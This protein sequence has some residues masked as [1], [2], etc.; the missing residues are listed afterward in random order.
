MSTKLRR[1]WLIV[2]LSV[3]ALALATAAAVSIQTGET[4]SAQE[5]QTRPLTQQEAQKVA[6]G[7]KQLVNKSTEGLV[8]VQHADGT[9]S[10]DLQGR[11]QNVAVAKKNADGTITQAC[12]D[13]PEAA[14][15]FFQIDPQLI[16]DQATPKRSQTN[17]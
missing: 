14:A 1:R 5:T 11:F 16:E 7:I 15:R 17:P 6:Q 8:S 10:M 2:V 3:F 4:K 13:T 9:V 12:V